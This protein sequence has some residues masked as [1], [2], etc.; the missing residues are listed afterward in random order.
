MGVTIYVT[1]FKL[2]DSQRE[3]AKLGGGGGGTD[4]FG[5]LDCNGAI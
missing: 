5:N 2:A 1:K 3:S 4:F